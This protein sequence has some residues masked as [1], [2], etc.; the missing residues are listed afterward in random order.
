MHLVRLF[1]NHQASDRF[2]LCGRQ[3]VQCPNWFA[4]RRTQPH[5]ERNWPVKQ[6]SCQSYS[7]IARI[8]SKGFPGSR[9][10]ASVQARP[11]RLPRHREL[12]TLMEMKCRFHVFSRLE[13]V[14][15]DFGYGCDHPQALHPHPSAPVSLRRTNDLSINMATVYAAPVSRL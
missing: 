7:E 2:T 1:A 5:T 11:C 15:A 9:R 10:G 4:K 13:R 14:T 6:R 3:V 12:L 8:L